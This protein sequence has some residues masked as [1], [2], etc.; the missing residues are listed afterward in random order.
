MIGQPGAQQIVGIDHANENTITQGWHYALINNLILTLETFE[1]TMEDLCII[2][3][4]ASY[5]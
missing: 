3:T 4:S 2:G 1:I 5:Y